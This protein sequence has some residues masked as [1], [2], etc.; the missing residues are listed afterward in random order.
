MEYRHQMDQYWS[1]DYEI[2]VDR[3]LTSTAFDRRHSHLKRRLVRQ[4]S[5]TLAAGLGMYPFFF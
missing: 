4:D 1:P 3:K 5:N 2:G